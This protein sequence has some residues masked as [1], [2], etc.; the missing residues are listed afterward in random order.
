MCR[1]WSGNR[2]LRISRLQLLQP[3]CT[4]AAPGVTPST[5]KIVRK[6]P[7]RYCYLPQQPEKQPIIVLFCPG[8]SISNSSKPGQNRTLSDACP[9]FLTKQIQIM[10]TQRRG[11]SVDI[12][13]GGQW[14]GRQV[15]KT[16][17][18]NGVGAAS[19]LQLSDNSAGRGAS[20]WCGQRAD[21][22]VAAAAGNGTASRWPFVAFTRALRADMRLWL[23]AGH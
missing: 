22:L 16:T 10:A 15:W 3:D 6:C 19:W 1:S 2:G 9:F 17:R 12:H 18:D 13:A 4:P 23:L 11:I 5:P 8:L 14:R 21:I 20:S 7:V